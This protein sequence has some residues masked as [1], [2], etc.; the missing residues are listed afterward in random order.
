MSRRELVDEVKKRSAVLGVLLLLLLL[1]LLLDRSLRKANRG[2]DLA[3]SGRAHH[4][5][6]SAV[7]GKYE[8]RLLLEMLPGRRCLR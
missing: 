5:S 1:L 4:Q 2:R 3:S 8:R 7:V 6:G